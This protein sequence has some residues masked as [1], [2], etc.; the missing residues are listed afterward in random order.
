M[1]VYTAHVSHALLDRFQYPNQPPTAAAKPLIQLDHHRVPY[2]PQAT[3]RH[4]L[5]AAVSITAIVKPNPEKTP[6]CKKRALSP[7]SKI[8]S[9]KQHQ[10]SEYPRE[11]LASLD[12][13][14]ER[15]S[16]PP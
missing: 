12:V 16:Q 6:H 14:L 9:P 10:S 4:R 5:L 15:H 3:F 8:V 2:E 13:N 1:H 11:P 7:H